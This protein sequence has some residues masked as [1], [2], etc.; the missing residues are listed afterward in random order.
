MDAQGVKLE[1]ATGRDSAP[2][3][4]CTTIHTQLDNRIAHF[5]PG[6]EA[7]PGDTIVAGARD[8]SPHRPHG[9]R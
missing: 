8:D 1:E 6:G 9:R 4:R 7:D 2:G 3:H 5:S